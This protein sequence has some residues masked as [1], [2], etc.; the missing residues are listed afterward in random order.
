MSGEDCQPVPIAIGIT[1]GYQFDCQYFDKLNMTI[2]LTFWTA[3]FIYFRMY[4]INPGYRSFFLH[5][6]AFPLHQNLQQRR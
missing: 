6:P 3:S 5:G 1:E 4:S 2:K